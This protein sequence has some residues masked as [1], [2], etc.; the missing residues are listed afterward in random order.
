MNGRTVRP[1]PPFRPLMAAASNAVRN[2]RLA[3]Q[4]PQQQQQQQQPLAPALQLKPLPVP[5]FAAL[6]ESIAKVTVQPPT[7]PQKSVH[8]P[9]QKP[10][11]SSSASQLNRLFQSPTALQPMASTFASQQ[12]QPMA[13]T[14]VSQQQLP[15]ASSAIPS[16]QYPSPIYYHN[17]MQQAANRRLNVSTPQYNDFYPT[18]AD[19]KSIGFWLG[20]LN[21]SLLYLYKKKI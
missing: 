14:F 21:F 5:A 19:F 9:P 4:Q 13:S 3:Q 15:I 17:A 18:R 20:R 7:A 8:S 11:P 12:L 6:P 1:V 2:V 16:P 10:I